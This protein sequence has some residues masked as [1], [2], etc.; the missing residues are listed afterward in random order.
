MGALVKAVF[1]LDHVLMRDGQIYRVLGNLHHPEVFLGYNI[2]SPHEGGDRMFRGIAYKKNFIEDER[3][4]PDAFDAFSMLRTGEIEEHRDPFRAARENSGT[5][6][7]SVWFG[8]Y[9][10]LVRIFGSDAVGIFGSSMFNLHLTPSGHVRKDIDFVV[11]G[12]ENVGL[13][14]RHLPVIRARLGFTPV[15]FERQARQ[16]RRYQRV[17]RH[18]NNTIAPVIS[19][20]WTALQLSNDIVTTIRFREPG[21]RMPFY[22][23]S[24]RPEAISDVTV[25]GEVADADTA[26]LFPRMFSLL[27]KCGRLT[28]Y[29]FWWKFSSPVQDGDTV[30]LRGSLLHLAGQPVVRISSFTDHWLQIHNP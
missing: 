8:L 1:D 10:E 11:Q 23:A 17:F 27:T 5:F 13:L 12:V 25:S 4:P 7:N 28:V 14:R 22:L 24:A 29:L 19:R 16:S 30:T 9:A 21:L 20:R 26:N 18:E 3:L 6:L 15:N 2:Y